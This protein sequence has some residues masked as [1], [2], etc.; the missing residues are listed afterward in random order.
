MP[1]MSR[2]FSAPGDTIRAFWRRLSPLP[3]GTWIFSRVLGRLVPYSATIRPHV[4][5]LEAG[6]ARVTMRDR[7][8]VRQHLG[9][10]HAVALANL[11]EL[12]SG[13]AMLGGMPRTVRGI[14]TGLS[15]T[16]HKKA[17]GPLTAECRCAVPDV[18][19]DTDYTVTADITDAAGDLVA[20][21]TVHWRLG[22]RPA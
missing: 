22:P 12:T 9:S 21:V 1:A 10:V 3:G 2:D 16:F 4:R 20:R 17:R 18:R 5:A 11:G 13:L 6:Y 19:A 14:V 7:R 15:I 8:A